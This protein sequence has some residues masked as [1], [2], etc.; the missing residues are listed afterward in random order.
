MQI[1]WERFNYE[2]L[3][4]ILW[5]FFILSMHYSNVDDRLNFELKKEKKMLNED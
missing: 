2:K 4:S 3:V 1:F 5:N